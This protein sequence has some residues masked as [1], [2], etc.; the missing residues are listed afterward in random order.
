MSFVKS[1]VAGYVA[2]NEKVLVAKS[3]LGAKTLQS[4]KYQPGVKGSAQINTLT[5]G[6]TVQA[7]SCGWSAAGTTTLS[8]RNIVT[9]QF[10]V[11][12]ALCETDLV[13][14]FAEWELN[15]AVGKEVLPFAEMIADAKVKGIAK[16]V[17]LLAWNGDTDIT[18][19]NYLNVTDGLVKII[20]AASGVV[21]A[22]AT[23][24]VT[25]L[26]NTIDAIN[27]MVANIPVEVIDADDLT[28]FTGYDVVMKYI[29]A[30]NASNQFA[31]TLM[32]DGKTMSVTIPNTMIKLQGVGGLNTKNKAYLTP[33][34]NLVAGGDIQGDEAQ[35]KLW[36]SDDNQ[37]FRFVNKFNIG[38]NCAF[39]SYIVK[40]TK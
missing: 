16:A 8:K 12:E 38:F 15:V 7:G 11:N 14:T 39:P 6:V 28:I 22:T 40:Y 2:Q 30:Y 23:G 37:E 9:G 20:G 18:G 10:K 21:D 27:L 35:F 25:L 17:E 5:D 26:A 13:G 29:A 32:L 4:I 19:T 1:D 3:V 31:G 36:Y 34:S 24:S 33:A